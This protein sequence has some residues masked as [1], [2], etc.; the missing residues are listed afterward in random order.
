MT[1]VDFPVEAGGRRSSVAFGKAV[2]ADALRGVDPG[3]A[4]AVLAERDWRKGYP[5]HFRAL[6]EAGLGEEAYGIAS[7]GLDSVRKR[8]PLADSLA[9]GPERPLE[10]VTVDGGGRPETEVTLPVRG[11]LLRGDGLARQL[12]TW[13]ADGVIEPSCSDII[14]QVMKNPDMLHLGD[15][16]MVVLGAGAEMGPLTALLGWGNTV[17]GVDRPQVQPRLL[18]AARETAG[19]L[20]APAH[21]ADL[22]NDLAAV[23][24]WLESVDRRLII[25]NYVYAPGGLHTLLSIAV[26]ALGSYLTS[27]RDDT[28]LA[29]L[30][31]PTD[32]FAVPPEVVAQASDRFGHRS[33]SARLTGTLSGGRLLRRNYPEDADPGINDS[34]VL[35]QGP[36]YALAKRIQRWR[37]TVARHERTVAFSVAP[38]TRTRSVT[39][40]RLLAAAYA[41][42]HRFD[43]DVFEPETARKLMA[44]LLVHQIQN[45]RPPAAESWRDEAFGAAHGGLWRSAYAPRS[46]LPLAIVLPK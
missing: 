23:A 17:I 18:A 14:H 28:A 8:I 13:V 46:A 2:V 15:Q 40:N 20:I 31:T 26:D 41:G 39:N 43:V 42:A 30:A 33:R 9:D 4:D 25:G 19:T 34:I 7:A 32:V 27:R 35:Q 24:Q 45:P 10:T 3:A 44:L 36:N 37:A 6:V 11:E 1:A 16:R 21:G 22:R 12:E 5:R 38:A 29:F